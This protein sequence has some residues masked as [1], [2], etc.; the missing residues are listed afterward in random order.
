MLEKIGDFIDPY[1]DSEERLEWFYNPT[2]KEYYINIRDVAKLTTEGVEDLLALC[3]YHHQDLVD[4]KRR[5]FV[6]LLR[7]DNRLYKI[8]RSKAINERIKQLEIKLPYELELVAFIVVGDMYK[9]ERWLHRK[10]A[11]KRKRGEWFELEE[12]DIEFIKAM[13][14]R[15]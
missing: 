2:Q 12:V 1:S 10:F 13:E 9:V 11:D 14:E 5:G 6:Y 3:F 8:G 4:K 15:L 7:A